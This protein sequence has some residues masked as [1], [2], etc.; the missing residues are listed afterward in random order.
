MIDRGRAIL[1]VEPYDRGWFWSVSVGLFAADE[2]G[3]K[4]YGAN[5]ASADLALQAAFSEWPELPAL[6]YTGAP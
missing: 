2:M 6:I 1:S 3:R 4:N 5:F